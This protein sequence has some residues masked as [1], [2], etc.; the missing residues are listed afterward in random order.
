[1]KIQ[2]LIT[3]TKKVKWQDL[4]DLQPENLKL[5]YHAEK[6]K[7]SIME[8]GFAQAIYVWQDPETQNTYICDGHTRKE[9]L[10][11]LINDGFDV[12]EELNCTFLDNTRIK[13][14]EEAI[15]Y[16]L[17]VFNVKR[18]PI[19]SEVLE[20]WLEEVDLSIDDVAFDDLDLKFEVEDGEVEIEKL[21]P[22]EKDDEVR[23]P[24]EKY[25]FVKKGD[26]WLLGKHRLVC[27]DSTQITDV[28][29]L[30]EGGKAD[31]VFTDPP[32]GVSY[33]KKTQEVFQTN[34][35]TEIKNDDKSGEDLKCFFNDIFSSYNTILNDNASYY[36]CSPQ[37]G[38]AEMMMMMMMRQ[39]NMKCRHQLIW[40]KDAPVFSMGR[41]DYD[42]QHEPILYG[43]KKKHNFYGEGDQKKSIWHFK[44]LE[45]KLHPT[46]KPVEMIVNAILNSSIL[47]NIVVDLFAGSGSTLIACEK[48][49]RI[50]YTMELDE[51]YCGVVINRYKDFV[52]SDKDIFLLQDGKKI[53]F[54]EIVN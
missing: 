10:I 18:N 15:K 14:K 43:W 32:Y 28:E 52:G 27:G 11:E 54:A 41:L 46:M 50:C 36:V 9:I 34:N 24:A 33:T 29:K 7:K 26:V 25:T 20:S 16:L 19:D 17:R 2:D 6:T 49:N 8:L 45:N 53:P 23:E 22:S 3:Q 51:H 21:A 1:M 35:Y 44:R 12:P 5:P 42:Y 4:K 39:N 48:T 47:N 38:D 13:T 40:V 30:M 37:G 31:M